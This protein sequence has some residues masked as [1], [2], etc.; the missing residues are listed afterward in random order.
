[1]RFR[2]WVLGGALLSAAAMG[3]QPA[4]TRDVVFEVEGRGKFVVEIRKDQA[5]QLSA[6]FLGLVRRGFYNRLLF[7]RKVD[8]FVIQAG[9]P[10]SRSWTPERARSKPGPMGGTEG[11]G[12]GGSGKNVPYEINDLTHEKHTI[13]MA[14]EAPMSNTG[15]SQFFINLKDNFRLNGL[16]CVFGRVTE[17]EEVVE[18]VQRGD[19]ITSV[20]ILP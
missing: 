11:M 19:R 2:H 10:K 8:N 7:H 4:I 5:P 13:G 18:S 3:G 12:D 6:H 14:L 16:Y 17:G 15:D 1:M 9:D 20:K